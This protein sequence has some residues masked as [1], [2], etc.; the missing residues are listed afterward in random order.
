[1][2]E[3]DLRISTEN[4]IMNGI[5]VHSPS[6]NTFLAEEMNLALGEF[7]YNALTG[8]IMDT[9]SSR[10]MLKCT[11]FHKLYQGLLLFNPWVASTIKQQLGDT[12]EFKKVNCE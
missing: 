3:I 1:M 12:F 11:T 7:F 2:I 5:S 8:P 10:K 4:I 6:S 9:K